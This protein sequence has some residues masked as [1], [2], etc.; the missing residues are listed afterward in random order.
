MPDDPAIPIQA[1]TSSTPVG[2][3]PVLPPLLGLA[4]IRLRV[5][6]GLR[7]LHAAITLRYRYHGLD[8]L[9]VVAAAGYYAVHPGDASQVLLAHLGVCDD[10]LVLA[11]AGRWLNSDIED[12]LEWEQRHQRARGHATPAP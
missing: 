6:A 12:F 4:G 7:L 11:L 9:L 8:T 2:G 5:R 3:P 10:L 1:P